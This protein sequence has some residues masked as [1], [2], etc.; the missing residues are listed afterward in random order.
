[1]RLAPQRMKALRKVPPRLERDDLVSVLK[2]VTNTHE[3]LDRHLAHRHRLTGAFASRA[4]VPDQI[5]RRVVNALGR[6]MGRELSFR[7]EVALGFS[8]VFLKLPW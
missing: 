5:T 3:L 4:D 8:V 2:V 7:T 6:W 1:M